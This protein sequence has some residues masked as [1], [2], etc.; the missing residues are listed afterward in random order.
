[1]EK[2]NFYSSISGWH[3]SG[4]K[5]RNVFVPRGNENNKVINLTGEQKRTELR[6]SSEHQGNEIT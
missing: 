3:H 5:H 1:M 6:N 2:M 4:G